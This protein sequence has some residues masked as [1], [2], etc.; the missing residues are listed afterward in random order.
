MYKIR[1]SK[2]AMRDIHLLKAAHLDSKAKQLIS[3]IERN[4][5]QNPPSYEKLLG[6]LAGKLSRRINHQHR[7]VY[8]V[9][10][11]EKVV[12]IISLWSHYEF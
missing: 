8:E 3:L 11:N 12:K 2:K 7:I 4:P 10:E 9:F 6:E 5:Y 1:Y